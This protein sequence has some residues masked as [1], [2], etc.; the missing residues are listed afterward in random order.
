MSTVGQRF[1]LILSAKLVMEQIAT[2][3]RVPSKLSRQPE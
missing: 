3:I 1:T 2:D